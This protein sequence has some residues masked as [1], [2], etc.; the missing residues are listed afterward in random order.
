MPCRRGAANNPS[1]QD[2]ASEVQRTTQVHPPG[3]VWIGVGCGGRCNAG[4]VQDVRRRMGLQRRFDGGV[5]GH[6][7]RRHFAEDGVRPGLLSCCDHLD[8]L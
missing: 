1:R 7:K 3:Q 2:R 4:E 6:V 5:V 8:R